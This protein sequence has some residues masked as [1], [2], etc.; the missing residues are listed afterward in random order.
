MYFYSISIMIKKKKINDKRCESMEKNLQDYEIEIKETLSKIISVRAKSLSDA[1]A[2][3]KEQYRKC[4][5]ELYSEDL[6]STDFNE[7]HDSLSETKENLYDMYSREDKYQ[8]ISDE[9]YTVDEI[10]AILKNLPPDFR[11]SV[12]GEGF[13]ISVN[14]VKKTVLL[15]NINYLRNLES[16]NN[17]KNIADEQ[18][19]KN[20][21]FKPKK[22]R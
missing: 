9:L 15:D 1:I 8:I 4:D 21:S 10:I 16:E 17:E 18:S 2:N 20:F 22:R 19:K 13:G 11:I 6:V 7:Y 12:A 3:V 5:I 14:N